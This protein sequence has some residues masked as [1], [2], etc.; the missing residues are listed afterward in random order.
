MEGFV[1]NVQAVVVLLYCSCF[2]GVS[3]QLHN[4]MIR[5]ELNKLKAGIQIEG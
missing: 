3:L 1:L 2:Q 4:E 5:G